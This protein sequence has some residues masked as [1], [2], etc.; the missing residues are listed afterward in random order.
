MTGTPTP[1]GSSPATHRCEAPVPAAV[2]SISLI[3]PCYTTD[4]YEDLCR[5]FDSVRQQA[6][7]I[8]EL[9]VVV[10]QSRQLET[11]L[12][13]ELEGMTSTEVHLVFLDTVPAVSRARNRGVSEAS[14]DIIA[15]ADDDAILATDWALATRRF[16]HGDSDAIGVA[17]AIL[18]L[19]DSPAMEWFPRELWWMLSCTYWMATTPVPVRNGYGANMSFRREAFAD[20]RRFDE[21]LGISGWDTSGWRGVGGEEPEL[22]LRITASTGR[23]V[24]YVPEIRA[25]H[26]VRSSRLRCRSLSRRAYWEGR[27]KAT[28]SASAAHTPGVLHTEWTLLREMVRAHVGRVRLLVSRPYDAL[29]QEG[30]VILVVTLV[31]LGFID[32]KLRRIRTGVSGGASGAREESAA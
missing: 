7:P 32:G 2:P 21:S 18:P 19:W 5:L 8:D 29:R 3:V 9:I 22:A 12:T 15:F 17:G 31:A 6:S 25:W 20:G 10:Q 4:R 14:C 1:D 16:Y 11:L 23:P 26:R 27:L 30:A 28:L 24:K 13:E